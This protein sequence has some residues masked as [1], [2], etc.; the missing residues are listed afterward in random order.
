MIKLPSFTL[1]ILASFGAFWLAGQINIGFNAVGVMILLFIPLFITLYLFPK[2]EFA[3]L[4]ETPLK[5]PEKDITSGQL[6]D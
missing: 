3:E 1:L 6:V 2:D 5:K 4:F